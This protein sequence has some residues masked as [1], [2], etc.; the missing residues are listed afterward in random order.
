MPP[1]FEVPQELIDAIVELVDD[2]NALGTL[3]TVGTLFIVP[4][5]RRLFRALT[6]SLN[7][8]KRIHPFPAKFSRALALFTASPHL[9]SYVRQLTIILVRKE[10]PTEDPADI[11][12]VLERFVRLRCLVIQ[13]C[14]MTL[15]S[16][17]NIP[18]RTVTSL[19]AVL[20]RKG[21]FHSLEL[22]TI[23]GVPTSL[24]DH[25]IQSFPGLSMQIVGISRDDLHPL[26]PDAASKDNTT[27]SLM[28]LSVL[29]PQ[30]PDRFCDFFLEPHC[31]NSLR[32]LQ[33]LELLIAGY[34]IPHSNRFL[35]QSSFTSTLG[36]LVLVCHE[37]VFVSSSFVLP[38]LPALHTLEFRIEFA[39]PWYRPRWAHRT[40][41]RI[42]P[43]LPG[44]S[45]A[46]ET[47]LLGV[48]YYAQNDPYCPDPAAGGINFGFSPAP[49]PFDSAEH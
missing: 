20:R 33:R 40:V 5:Q 13:G 34:A 8:D 9:A 31:Q 46:L 38:L 17:A 49:Y 41:A 19:C 10:N 48:R 42:I 43:Q 11:G 27:S 3:A 36:H 47:L 37:P 45:P 30:F 44:S 14:P 16:W 21:S 39:H 15:G 4:C 24:L 2:T 23:A 7:P 6:L 1:T 12:P 25:A 22:T 29:E 18:Q 28:E 32:G 35:Q 26:F